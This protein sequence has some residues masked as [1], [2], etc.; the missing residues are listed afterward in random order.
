MLGLILAC[1]AK[2]WIAESVQTRNLKESGK[3]A[4]EFITRVS[5]HFALRL[6]PMET[7]LRQYQPL[8]FN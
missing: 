2:Q 4:N 8:L 5:R 6:S 1:T 7:G 3:S